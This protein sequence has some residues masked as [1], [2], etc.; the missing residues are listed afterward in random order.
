V[1]RAFTPL[2]EDLA[3][4]NGPAATRP[5]DP[6]V[7]PGRASSRRSAGPSASLRLRWNSQ[8]NHAQ[9]APGDVSTHTG[10]AARG[11]FDKTK[12]ASAPPLFKRHRCLIALSRDSAM[13]RRRLC[14]A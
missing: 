5:G 13:T 12:K 10:D 3:R 6:D 11:A 14:R 9:A 4:H 7:R 1:L 2:A 8:L